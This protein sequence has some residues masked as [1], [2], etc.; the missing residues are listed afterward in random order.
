MPSSPL[1]GGVHQLE[2]VRNGAVD[3]LRVGA[4]GA[5]RFHPASHLFG[6]TLEE[7][8]GGKAV[9]QLTCPCECQVNPLRCGPCL[10]HNWTSIGSQFVRNWY[11]LC[12]CEYNSKP[13]EI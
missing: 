2:L 4:T 7:A 11:E 12:S 5:A 1:I 8:H 9:G 3:H 13:S 10:W 6:T